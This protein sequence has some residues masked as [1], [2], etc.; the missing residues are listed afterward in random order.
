[1]FEFEKQ[2]GKKEG[3]VNGGPVSITYTQSGSSVR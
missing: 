3:R 1:M 2:R